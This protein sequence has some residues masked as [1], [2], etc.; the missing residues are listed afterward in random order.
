M[1]SGIK[2]KMNL[3]VSEKTWKW[4]IYGSTGEINLTIPKDYKVIDDSRYWLRIN[5]D[6]QSFENK[7]QLK[8]IFPT[9]QNEIETY[10]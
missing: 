7:R 6:M 10:Q 4:K 9:I 3:N 8:K 1:I 5:D 2:D